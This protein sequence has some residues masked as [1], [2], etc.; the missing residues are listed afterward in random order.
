MTSVSSCMESH[1]C[2]I[3]ISCRASHA[4]FCTWNRSIAR[5]AY[6]KHR[7]TMRFILLERS[8]VTSFTMERRFSGIT[9]YQWYPMSLYFSPEQLGFL[10]YRRLL[11]WTL[12]YKA[13]RHWWLF[14][15]YRVSFPYSWEDKPLVSVGKFTPLAITAQYFLALFLKSTPVYMIIVVK[16]TVGRRPRLHTLLLKKRK[17][18]GVAGILRL[19]IV[20][21][22]SETI[23][24]MQ[25]LTAA[26]VGYQVN[27]L[28]AD[29]EVPCCYRR[30]EAFGLLYSDYSGSRKVFLI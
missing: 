2:A 11:D 19:D 18:F 30:L 9:A 23:V 4:S 14:R 20:I 13:H 26:T 17:L 21:R 16:R 27:G 28:V 24:C 22:K 1:R 5:S 10:F 29:W 12:W 25:I 6:V 3:L 7:R 8:M 15:L